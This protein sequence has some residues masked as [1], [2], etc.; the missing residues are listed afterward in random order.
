MFGSVSEEAPALL[1][2]FRSEQQLRIAGVL[3][4]P[5]S[6]PLSVGE[7]AQRA[8]VSKATASHEVSRL[9]RHGVVLEQRIGRTRFVSAN[10]SLPWADD[11]QAMLAK[12]VGVPAM[13]AA[14]LSD[15]DGIEEAWV[16][17]S[18]AAR[19]LGEPGPPPADIDVLVI[20]T[21]ELRRV[22]SACRHVEAQVR[23]EVN[24]IVVERRAWDDADDG[25]MANVREGPMVP[26]P[27]L[28][29][30]SR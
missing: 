14:A 2:F 13:L 8:N 5:E 29:P 26:V 21:A 15:V 6:E 22:R 18:W 1:P 11:L 10:R 12:T 24:P 25:F 16:F 27:L 30:A 28:T 17:G 3:F 4:A 23:R 7:L 9:V 20:G 19:F